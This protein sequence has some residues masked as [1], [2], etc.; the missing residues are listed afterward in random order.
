MNLWT[1]KSIDLAGQSNY[2]DQLYRV[3][4]MSVNVRR[5]LSE[6][7]QNEIRTYLNN[8]NGKNLLNVL[9]EQEI[10]PIKDSYVAYLKRDKTAINRNPATV[11]RL[12][13]M[14][15][16]MGFDEILDKTTVP[17]ET[18]RQIGPLFKNWISSGALGVPVTDDVEKF[19]S[20]QDNI[21]FNASDKAMQNFAKNHLGYQHEKGLDFIAKFNNKFIIG[22]AKFLT[23]FGGHQNA[24]FNDAITTMRAPLAESD[25]TVQTIAILDGVLYIKGQNKMFKDLSSF[26]DNE[27]VISTVLLRDY[28]FSV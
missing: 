5:E 10:F 21:V 8:Q 6:S 14:L 19:L 3:Y 26:K 13:G 1:Q 12:A 4:P 18:N 16:E 24:Q 22:E 15:I 7:T 20:Y 2:L 11:S 9:L 28:L 25:Y 17:K 27:V 23:D